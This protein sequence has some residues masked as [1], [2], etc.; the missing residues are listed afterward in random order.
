MQNTSRTIVVLGTGG[1]IAGTAADAADNVGYTA[2]QLGVESLVKAVPALAGL[3]LE[4]E[5]VA[6]AD[7]KDMGFA[8]WR[9]L[10]LRVAHHLAR[11]DV[12]GVVVTHGTDTL[13][14][15]AYFLQRVLAP[16]KPVAMTAAMRPATSLNADGPQN[17]LDAVTVAG[18]SGAQGVV[19]VVAGAVHAAVD[20]RKAHTYRLDAFTSGDAGVLGVVEEGRTT[21]WRAW[22]QGEAL[23]LQWLPVEDDA[24]PQVE[25][26]TSH[27]GASGALVR[28]A[29]E[30]G[31]QG[32][33]VAATGNGTVHAALEAA[34]LEAQD[35][36]VTVW[37]SSR[38]GNGRVIGR[39]DDVLPSAGELT[40]V[41]ARVELI[42]QLLTPC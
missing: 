5:Q 13:E 38:C 14:E 32:L 27:A 33:V 1:T 40:P 41:K 23:G 3:P 11:D 2:A 10:A 21:A 26:V 19:V 29:C 16:T 28:A 8:I 22:P 36:G 35:Q 6:Q 9:S 15:T 18:T 30:I 7:S 31:V 20:V 25:I 39:A 17:L 42:L 37:R 24:W 12:A 34:L 4:C